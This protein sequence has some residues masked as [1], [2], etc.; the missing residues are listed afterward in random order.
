[1]IMYDMIIYKII[2]VMIIYD[3]ILYDMI[4]YDAAGI[5]D[6]IASDLEWLMQDYSVRIWKETCRSVNKVEDRL[7]ATIKIY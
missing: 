5:S 7:D 1:M 3:M 2:Y 6:N 4:M